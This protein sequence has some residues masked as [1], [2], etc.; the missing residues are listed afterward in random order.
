[1][2]MCVDIYFFY[3]GVYGA[4]LLFKCS[5]RVCVCICGDVMCVRASAVTY[6]LPLSLCCSAYRKCHIYHE[7]YA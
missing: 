4:Q 3:V 1:M 6:S 5:K 7:F 2:R